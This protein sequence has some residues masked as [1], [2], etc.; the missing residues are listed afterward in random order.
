[1]DLGEEGGLREV[2][3]ARG[4]R[5]VELVGEGRERAQPGRLEHGYHSW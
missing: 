1:V 4:A 5:E 3:R 2:Q